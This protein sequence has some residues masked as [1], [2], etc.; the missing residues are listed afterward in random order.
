MSS[1]FTQM[2]Y[3]PEGD[4]E[5]EEIEQEA[6]SLPPWM[7]PP[8]DEL[9]AVVPL[10]LVIGR[11]EN[12]VVALRHATVYSQGVTF[13][14]VALARGVSPKQS[15]RLIREQH[16]FDA[17]EPSDYFLRIGLELPDGNRV[18]NLGLRRGPRRWTGLDEEPGGPVFFEHGGGGSSGGGGRVSTSPSFWLWPLP[19]SGTIQV[20]C[21]WPVPE[22]PLASIELDVGPLV[23]ARA[24]VVPLWSGA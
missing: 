6:P 10:A 17:A 19:E 3:G 8:E 14:F 24:R 20:F 21:E 12:G 5:D 1:G 13:A 2:F 9:G 7:G 15:N 22:I 4:G 18:S 23:A 16:A 11:S